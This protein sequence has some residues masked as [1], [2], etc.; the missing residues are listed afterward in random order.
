[1]KTGIPETHLKLAKPDL[2]RRLQAGSTVSPAAAAADAARSGPSMAQLDAAADDSLNDP[3][4]AGVRLTERAPGPAFKRLAELW[5]TRLDHPVAHLYNFKARGLGFR[6]AG[7][8][9]ASAAGPASPARELSRTAGPPVRTLAQLSAEQDRDCPLI[10]GGQPARMLGVKLLADPS[11]VPFLAGCFRRRRLAWCY[12]RRSRDGWIEVDS[13][14][15]PP[16]RSTAHH[17]LLLP[18][19]N[20]ARVDAIAAALR[21]VRVG[22]AITKPAKPAA[23]VASASAT[24]SGP[25]S[26][27][28][29]LK[30]RLS[31]FRRSEAAAAAA[32]P[33]RVVPVTSHE[34][35]LVARG[36]AHLGADLAVLVLHTAPAGAADEGRLRS[37]EVVMPSPQAVGGVA[38]GELSADIADVDHL[39]SS[40]PVRIPCSSGNTFADTR[41]CRIPVD[42]LVS[43]CAVRGTP[44][45]MPPEEPP[46]PGQDDPLDAATRAEA[47]RVYQPRV[48]SRVPSVNAIDPATG[49]PAGPGKDTLATLLA[50]REEEDFVET[51]RDLNLLVALSQ[52]LPDAV[53]PMAAFLAAE[54]GR[55]GAAAGAE[56]QCLALSDA[57]RIARALASGDRATVELFQSRVEH[58]ATGQFRDPALRAQG[59][60]SPLLSDRDLVNQIVSLH[61]SKVS[62]QAGCAVRSRCPLCSAAATDDEAR[63][64]EYDIVAHL[65]AVHGRLVNSV[66]STRRERGGSAADEGETPVAPAAPWAASLLAGLPASKPAPTPA[67]TLAPT[68]AAGAGAAGLSSLLAQLGAAAAGEQSG[69]SGLPPF[70][71]PLGYG[72]AT[73]SGEAALSGVFAAMT[74]GSPSSPPAAT[75]DSHGFGTPSNLGG[76]DDESA[77]SDDDDGPSAQEID[78]VMAVTQC[79]ED[80]ARQALLEH[81]GNMEAA[82]MS[83]LD[84]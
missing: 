29:P 64:C 77:S 25:P 39:V 42:L 59:K 37:M 4:K 54:A 23:A 68:S 16:Q 14:Y 38:S 1:M 20:A 24:T 44:S 45:L 3:L 73:T 79:T 83:C 75:A 30:Q 60:F 2:S 67:P 49:Q 80:M 81:H 82:I 63:A 74:P 22:I 21:L 40:R 57:C 46:K 7:P 41:T 66:I 17:V 11:R 36:S 15:E 58:W 35:L 12:G 9:A 78:Q 19:E 5:A 70:P 31:S 8:T 26:T 33:S 27:S 65:K 55:G 53:D 51:M 72:A 52:P 62:P 56:S 28:S 47:R 69:K 6:G 48:H 71:P 76:S 34:L 61:G 18:D 10:R 84:A 32:P 43:H 13:L 50:Q